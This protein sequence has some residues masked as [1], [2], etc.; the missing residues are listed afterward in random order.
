MQN[1]K[2]YHAPMHTA[3][4]IL[5]QTMVRKF[6]ID[7][8]FSTHVEKKKSKCDYH[9]NR[10]LS[11]DEISNIEKTV[12]KVIRMNLPVSEDFMELKHATSQFNLS[13]LPETAKE[14]IRI[15]KVG[16]YDACPCSGNHVQNTSEIGQFKVVSTTFSDNRLRIRFRLI[17][18]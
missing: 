1:K 17:D 10:E 16:D 7:R 5:N 2:E 3:E 11:V 6:G 12:N 4:H 15:I 18:S 14:T 9:F 8:S 13:R